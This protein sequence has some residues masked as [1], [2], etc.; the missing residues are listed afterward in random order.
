MTQYN[1]LCDLG[2]TIVHGHDDTENIPVQ[3][4][5]RACRERLNFLEKNPIKALEAFGF[6]D[7]YET[8][9]AD[10]DE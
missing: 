2:F 9:E 5:I 1:T 4:L 6:L 3:D 7:T 10:K 8:E